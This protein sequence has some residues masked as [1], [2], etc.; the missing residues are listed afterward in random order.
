MTNDIVC[1]APTRQSESVRSPFVTVVPQFC[2]RG[3]KKNWGQEEVAIISRS[4]KFPTEKLV[5]NV[6][7]RRIWLQKVLGASDFHCDYPRNGL[8]NRR[9]FARLWFNFVYFRPLT[10]VIDRSFDYIAQAY[11]LSCMTVQQ[12][13]IFPTRRKFSD[14]GDGLTFGRDI[15]HCHDATVP[16]SIQFYPRMH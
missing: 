13:T 7:C 2:G 6:C 4:C 15:C 9:H 16:Q 12:Q 5:S 14:R 1:I 10:K 3:I 8:A 11:W